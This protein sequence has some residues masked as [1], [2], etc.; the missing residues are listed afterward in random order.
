MDYKKELK[1]LVETVKANAK[2]SGQKLSNEEIA[3][4]I[5]KTRTYLSDLLNPEGPNVSEGIIA[6]FKQKFHYELQGATIPGEP[7]DP[8]NL[9]RAY[10]KTIVQRQA[11][12]EARITGRKREDILAEIERETIENLKELE[13]PR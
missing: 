13:R 10:V 6:V 12:F 9:V 3:K 2:A 4:R 1:R 11:D 7:K 5:G 8:N